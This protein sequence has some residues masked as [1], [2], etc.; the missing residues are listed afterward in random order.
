MNISDVNQPMIVSIPRVNFNF[1]NTKQ[2][3]VR[4]LCFVLLFSLLN[5]FCQFDR[6]EVT[7]ESLV[8]FIFKY[9]CLVFIRNRSISV[10]LELVLVQFSTNIKKYNHKIKTIFFIIVH[11]ICAESCL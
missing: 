5:F 8:S 6:I 4:S 2:T 10:G 9:I 1:L 3:E 11:F 7:F